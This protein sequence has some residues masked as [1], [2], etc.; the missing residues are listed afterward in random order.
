V[1]DHD[2]AKR[3]PHGEES[4]GLQTIE[5]A[6]RIPPDEENLDYRKMKR[7]PKYLFGES[8]TTRRHTLLQCFMTSHRPA[9]LS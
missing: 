6:Q 5:V 3:D 4:E 1:S 9:R 8:L 2:S 7:I